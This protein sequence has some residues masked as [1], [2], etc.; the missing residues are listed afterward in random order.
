MKFAARLRLASKVLFGRGFE[1]VHFQDGHA[2]AKAE[3]TLQTI[4]VERQKRGASFAGW[5]VE[6]HMSVWVPFWLE[7]QDTTGALAVVRQGLAQTVA[8]MRWDS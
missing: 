1:L 4:M 5:Q 3:E 6:P 8:V 2:A 7:T